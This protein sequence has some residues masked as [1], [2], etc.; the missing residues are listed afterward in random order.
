MHR[1]PYCIINWKSGLLLVCICSMTVGAEPRNQAR[2]VDTGRSDSTELLIDWEAAEAVDAFQNSQMSQLT[3]AEML[4][5]SAQH[6]IGMALQNDR[7]SVLVYFDT[8]LARGVADPRIAVRTLTQQRQGVVRHEYKSV[9]PNVINVRN[10][11]TSAI[12]EL[13]NMP[14]V[15]KVEMDEYHPDVVRLHDSIPLIRG[16]QSQIT[17]AGFSADGA[18][19]RIC[20]VDTG[21]DS[22]H[23]MYSSRIDASAG[24]D[25]YN[26]DSNPEDDNGHGSH[27]AG[28]AAGGTGL[29]VDFGCGSGS[30]VFQGVAPAA[31]L[32]GVKVLNSA[33]GGFDSDII[34]GINHCAD[35]S[36]SGGQSDVINMSIGTG[37]FTSGSCT[38]SWAVAANNASANGVVAIAASG[39]ENNSNS[40][41]SPA[42]GANVIAVGMTW[43]N[44]YPTCEDPTTNWGWGI[45]T[46][47]GP[48][49]DEVGCFSNES[50]FLDVAAPG[51]N[52]W[53]ASNAAGGGSITGKSGT[54]MSCPTVVGL[55]AL[56]LGLDPSLTP[57]EV[58]QIIRD[59]AI[60]MGPAGFDRA[61]GW[62]RI[63]V[64]NTLA[65]VA[66]GCSVDPDCDDGVFCNGAETCVAGSCQSGTTV[67]CNDGVSCTNDSCNEGT[68][69][70]D[71]IV[72]N[73]SCDNGLFCDGVETC[74]AIND[75]QSGTAVNC[76]DGVSC[77]MD[78][79]NEGTDSC[80]N[81]PSNGLCDDGIFCNG[82]E[83]CDALND[84][85]AGTSVN[86]N[87]GVG[88]TDDSCNE[89]TDSCDNIANNANCDNG[90][91]CDGAETCDVGLDCQAGSDPCPGQTCDEVGDVCVDCQVDGD[92]DDG[93]FC[94]GV[95]TCS[96][97]V[98]QS[99]STVNCNDGVGCTDDSCNEVTDSCDNTA[100]N[101]NCDNGQF[102]DGAETCDA[103][104]DCQAGTTVNCDD[105]VGCTTDACDE[106]SDTCTH[107]PVN[108]SCDDGIFCNGAESCDIALDCQ[109]GSAPSCDDGVACTDD[110]CNGGTDS[111]DNI[112]NNGNCDDGLF[113]N[114]AETCDAGLDCQSGSDPCPG[115]SCDESADM[116]LAGPSAK[117]EGGTVTAG[118]LAIT[119]NLS[120][121]YVS[122]VVVCSQQYNNN[123]EP[124]VPRVSNVTSTSFDVRLDNPSGGA[125]SA[126]NINYFVVEE[127]TW[128]IDGVNI[129]AQTYVSTV[130]DEN[131][132]W[133]GQSQSYGQSYTNPVVFGQVMTENDA[134]WSVFWCQGSS[135]TAPP[136]AATLVTGK[137]VC[138]DINVTRSNETVG[139][140]V[141]EADSGSIGGVN[142]EAA[143]G[144]DTVA[145][146]TDSPPYVYNFASSFAAAPQ[147]AVTQM[148]A[149]D[150]NNGGWS[151]AHGATQTTATSLFLSIEEDVI[152]D[153]ERNHTTEQVGY[154]VFETSVV[155]PN[156]PQC[157]IDPDCDDGLFCNGA[158]TCV[159]GA[160]QSGSTVNCDDGI[161]CTD[162]SCNETTD[163]CDNSAND[164]NCDNGLFCDGNE[165]C[166]A[167]LD[168]QS[169]S[170]I[171]CDDGVNCT[172]DNCNEG[173]D[174][175][176]NT[177]N[178][179]ACDNGEFCDGAETCD[180]IF[181]CVAGTS[182][183][184]DDGVSCTDDSCNEASDQCDNTANDTNCDDG[185]FCNG[186]ETC[187]AVLDCQNGN[188]PCDDGVGCTI[189]TCDEGLDTCSNTANDASCDNGLFCDGAESCN[190]VLDCQSGSDPCPGE[191]CDEVGNQ[192]ISGPVAKME[193]VS[194]VVGSSPVTVGL[195]NS[196]VSAVVVCT[197]N[198]TDNTTP[199][200]TRISNVT[201]SSF[202]VRLQNPSNGVVATE[203]VN[204]LVVEEGTWTIDG[205]NIEAQTYLSTVTD[206]NNSW[207]AQA[208]TYSQSYNSPVVLGQVMSENDANW[209]VFW[210]QGTSRSNP[211]IAS[212][213]RTG[214]TV[215]ED[216]TV[217]RANETIGF[218]V[219]EASSGTIGGVAFEAA[220]GADTVL[221][222][223]NSPPYTYT[224]NAAFS[225]APQIAVV[226][227]AAMDGGNGGWAQTHGA[228]MTSATS[229]FLSIDEDQVKDSERNHTSEQVGY[230]V[231]ETTVVIP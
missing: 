19:V 21:I 184:C 224:F 212:A 135:R 37:N 120:N 111:C 81:L 90:L 207:V 44:D 143:L 4:A 146:V 64:L 27:V 23:V 156:A 166:D 31:T 153:T 148:A 109:A 134:N 121:S 84:C 123:T 149:M 216:S 56:V 69:S 93:L 51:A 186:T 176:D 219:I 65:L 147:V 162:D 99:G 9:L 201:A 203:I 205:V 222:V 39:N 106:G 105:S 215:C 113:C 47:F 227:Q 38:H 104:L 16:T 213:L 97:G 26:N 128:T 57:A 110:S 173:T 180:P 168:C 170:T 34:A 116:C 100:N 154:I 119:V 1:T 136:S 83:T 91:F 122:P 2:Q 193:S 66:P 165:T 133:V 72:N 70:C 169:G 195:A 157:T 79:C 96:A 43:K 172:T 151:Q 14:G 75:C 25:F 139:F 145:G 138:E 74:D 108:S 32:I 3:K 188:D 190:A 102:C 129:E 211:P 196:Y 191:T 22:D 200:V 175:C 164:S 8:V 183:N 82:N 197:A 152:G 117:L 202:D 52:I 194:V 40:M 132:S 115:Q 107:T 167:V 103:I 210:C 61:Y 220:L 98:C 208:Q 229:M 89:A 127:G 53:S 182:V 5:E 155:Y 217:T 20:I 18:G 92:C 71:N 54:S 230:I 86:C 209:S 142:F 87:D 185:A 24:W 159:A 199:I 42:C 161:G 60:D 35:Q 228:T 178:N 126:E 144:A 225:S 158:E 231:F 192:C 206:E 214:K 11:P 46:D 45:C 88:C 171:N 6:E 68:D 48:Q 140:I 114:G 12:E 36:A 63:D 80:D 33:G 130:T 177:P 77:T 73:A 62:G 174:S 118:G 30:Q 124:T 137:T 150:G 17:G 55:A 94:N 50:D 41:G 226:T 163:S 189:D 76:N 198:Y 160:C 125:V 187:N 101:A 85:Q 95:E 67:N 181:D 204:C 112:A 7:H 10:I 49:T 218:I 28:I 13:R 223:T 78:T 131:N 58:R 141:V 15:V 179:G 29:S 221:G 59:G